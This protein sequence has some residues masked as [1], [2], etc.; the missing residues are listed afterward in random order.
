MA[1]GMKILA[2]DPGRTSGWA[3]YHGQTLVGSGATIR[4]KDDRKLFEIATEMFDCQIMA[5][6]D[7][8]DLVVIES[9]F[10]SR[11]LGAALSVARSA[12][13]WA[14]V[15]YHHDL[16]VSEVGPSEW[17]A[18]LNLP[19][20]AKRNRELLER[21]TRQTAERIKGAPIR[22]PDEAS[23]ICMGFWAAQKE[24]V[25]GCCLG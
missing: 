15:A 21:V 3:L 10:V 8:L 11:F 19:T 1:G 22:K 14:C 12:Q 18:L 24:N 20:G 25:I 5:T 17:Q 13:T 23:A 16:P 2:I 6:S 4:T 9:Q 7:C